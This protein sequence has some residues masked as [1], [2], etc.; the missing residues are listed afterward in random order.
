MAATK[1]A[2]IKIRII[3]NSLQARLAATYLRSK[4]VA[5]VLGRCIH[6]YGVSRQQFLADASWVKHELKHIEQFKKY[7][8]LKFLWMYFFETLRHGYFNNR[9]E[10]EARAAEN[11]HMDMAH[12][13]IQ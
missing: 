7:G 8:Y 9:Y 1:P 5:L 11:V 12:Y 3:E 10:A 2:K 6:L 13:E 4:S